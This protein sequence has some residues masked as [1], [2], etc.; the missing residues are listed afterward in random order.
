M[1]MP[2][3]VLMPAGFRAEAW[4]GGGAG[5]RVGAGAGAGVVEEGFLRCAEAGKRPRVL[6]SEAE[7]LPAR[8]PPEIQDQT[9][10]K[11]TAR[12]QR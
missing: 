8:T 7:A 4:G 5:V 11:S 12:L 6:A 9:R 1:V 3:I 10:V 2:T